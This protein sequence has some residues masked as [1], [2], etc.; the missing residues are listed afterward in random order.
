M[1]RWLNN[2]TAV[3]WSVAIISGLLSLY[4]ITNRDLINGD[5]IVYIDVAKSFLDKGIGGAIDVYHWPLYGILIGLVHK[6][7]GLSFENS[8][9]VLN[10]LFLMLVCVVFVRIY[11]EISGKEARIWVAAILVL[12]LPILNEYRELVIRGYGFWAFMLVALYYFIQYSRS[13]GLQSALKWQLGMTAAILF[14]VEGVAFL[15]FAPFCL[16]FM[17][18]ARNRIVTHLFRLNGLFI[19]LAV[20]GALGMLVSGGLT[21]PTSIE[22]PKQLGYTSPGG[23]LS[24]I[25]TEAGM[26]YGRNRFMASVEEARLIL[27]SGLLSLVIIKVSLNTGLVFLAVWGYG[28]HRKWIRLTRESYI[29][30]YFAAIGFLTL[31]PVAGNFFFISSR[32]TV[33]T[34]LLISLITFQYVDY[35]FRELSRRQLQKWSVAAGVLIFVLFMD[36][37][38]SG[39]A[40]KR[41]IRVAGE[42]IKDELATAG[43]IAC[44]EARLEFYSED[45]C[46]RIKFDNS[47][48]L[49]AING[50][51]DEGYTYLVLWVDRKQEQ[52]QSAADGALELEK[53]FLNDRG[54]SVRLY[55]MPSG[56]H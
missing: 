34:V 29:V 20:A 21:L 44:N 6:L 56:V 18:E 47:D 2:R 43:K 10:T 53:E 11:E 50:L 49:A 22:A 52:L 4:R 51:K 5:G 16:L 13:P 17:A 24:A 3:Y 55:R 9:S 1:Y 19:F 35:L 26:M 27:V 8:A 31:V 12:A 46:Q 32:Y 41:N 23:L 39:G 37:V 15:V 30:L 25:N 54:G 40:S 33:L 48:P 36:G 7:T 42:W 14:R 28:I 38:I 45:R